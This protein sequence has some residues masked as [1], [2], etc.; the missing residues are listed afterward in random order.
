MSETYPFPAPSLPDNAYLGIA[1]GT[2]ALPVTDIHLIFEP[3]ILE[4]TKLV[5]EHVSSLPVPPKA[6]L[7]IGGF[8]ESNYLCERLREALGGVEILRPPG[9]WRAVA[10][11]AVMMGLEAEAAEKEGRRSEERVKRYGIELVKRYDERLHSSIRRKRHW[12]GL[13]GCYKISVMHWFPEV[14]TLLVKAC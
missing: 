13:D 3:V 4:T 11:G 8:G 2:F 7:L 6:I 1:E 12:C 14:R 5:R 10:Q 9:A